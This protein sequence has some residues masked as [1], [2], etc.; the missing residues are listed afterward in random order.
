MAG[1]DLTVTGA[2]QKPFDLHKLGLEFMVKGPNPN[3]LSPL[4]GLPLP[5]LPLPAHGAGH[6]DRR[7]SCCVTSMPG[8]GDSD[9]QG[10]IRY[11]PGEEPAGAVRRHHLQKLDLDDIAGLIGAAPDVQ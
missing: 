7:R 9:A 10:G 1:T 4:L 3:R 6:H 2:V 8:S 5:S 11:V